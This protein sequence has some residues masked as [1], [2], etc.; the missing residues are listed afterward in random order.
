MS[1]F[2]LL[3]RYYIQKQKRKPDGCRAS[4]EESRWLLACQLSL[5][6]ALQVRLRFAVVLVTVVPFTFRFIVAEPLAVLPLLLADLLPVDQVE[7]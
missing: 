1:K 5:P 7:S 3:K 6:S 4:G 2:W